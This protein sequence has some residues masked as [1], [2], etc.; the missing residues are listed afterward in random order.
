M[1]SLPHEMP[2]GLLVTEPLPFRATWREYDCVTNVAVT[3][4]LTF[5]VTVQ[6]LLLVLSQPLQL[7]NVDPDAAVAVSLTGGPL[8]YDSAQSLPQEMPKGTLLT[9][10]VPEPDLLTDKVV[11]PH[12]PRCPVVSQSPSVVD[13]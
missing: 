12:D 8:V 11:V 5:I 4:L 10:P 2:D 6:V 13:Q 9:V 1:Q 7:E 3:D